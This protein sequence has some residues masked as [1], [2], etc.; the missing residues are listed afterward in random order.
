MHVGCAESHLSSSF[1]GPPWTHRVGAA[2]TGIDRD[3]PE[4]MDSREMQVGHHGEVQIIATNIDYAFLMQ[5][6]DRDFSIK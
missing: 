2:P 4:F 5:A 3:R 1:E 6:I